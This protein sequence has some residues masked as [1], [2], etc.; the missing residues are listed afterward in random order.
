KHPIESL[1]KMRGGTNAVRNPISQSAQELFWKV[2]APRKKRTQQHLP[3]TEE[4]HTLQIEELS[5]AGLIND[6]QITETGQ[7]IAQ[8]MHRGTR[9]LEV[10]LEYEDRV[11]YLTVIA[12]RSDAVVSSTAG[13]SA[14]YPPKRVTLELVGRE[15]ILRTVLTWISLTP[16]Y[17]RGTQ[18]QYTQKEIRTLVERPRDAGGWRNISVTIPNEVQFSLIESDTGTVYI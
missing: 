6:S 18:Q 9:V 7:R 4:Q 2:T 12:N 10:W 11:D 14:P 5:R 1:D 3:L 13:N 8:A 16:R 17:P 15:Q